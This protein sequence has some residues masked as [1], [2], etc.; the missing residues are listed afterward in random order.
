MGWKEK[1]RQLEK[2]FSFR[3]FKQALEFIN[4]VGG[5]AE[6]MNYYPEIFLHQKSKVLVTIYSKSLPITE[7]AKGLSKSIDG[8]KRS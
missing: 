8:V 1:N 4:R 7:E 6:N 5:V 2:Q 3:N